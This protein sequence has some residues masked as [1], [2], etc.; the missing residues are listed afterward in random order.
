MCFCERGHR[1]PVA[2]HSSCVARSLNLNCWHEYY[3][4]CHHIRCA[5]WSPLVHCGGI[6]RRDVQVSERNDCRARGGSSYRHRSFI[7][8]VSSSETPQSPRQPLA[9]GFGSTAGRVLLRCRHLLRSL[10]GESHH[11][12][13][14]CFHPVSICTFDAGHLVRGAQCY[15]NLCG[16]ALSALGFHDVRFP[17]VHSPKIAK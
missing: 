11:W 10:G 3:Y 16:R 2:I 13:G 6:R 12:R 8:S 14:E 1:A 5:K 9:R 15:F 4:T 7:C 17:K